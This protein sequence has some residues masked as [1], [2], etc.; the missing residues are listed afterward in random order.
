M[1][2]EP[3]DTI[4]NGKQGRPE[5]S[6]EQFQSWLEEMRPWLRAGQSLYYSMDKAGLQNHQATIYNKYA[7][8]DWFSI[9]VDALRGTVG[10]LVNAVGFKIIEAAHTRIIETEG[11][12][13]L[14]NEEVRIWQTMAE[15][16]RTAQPFFVTRTESAE[17]KDED[18]G[19]IL[20]TIEAT[21]YEQLGQKAGRQMVETD[22]P[23]QNQEQAGPD[24]DV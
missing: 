1:G 16:H 19:K 15:K 5:Y 22:Q 21:N 3:L 8:K 9:K 6:E 20:D 14:S 12:T 10:E 7:L 17:A 23:V 18:L 2:N 24:S 4:K 13:T 11:K